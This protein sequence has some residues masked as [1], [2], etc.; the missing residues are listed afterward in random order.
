MSCP[1]TRRRPLAPAAA[2][3]NAACSRLAMA[4]EVVQEAPG[5]GDGA[6]VGV[7]EGSLGGMEPG[8]DYMGLGEARTHNQATRT[9]TS[10]TASHPRRGI[11]GVRC[12]PS[13]IGRKTGS[14]CGADLM[15]CGRD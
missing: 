14:C 11:A 12:L 6:G 8:G 4:A 15:G 5:G 7:R 2:V 3:I 1:R 10:T 13:A 9:S